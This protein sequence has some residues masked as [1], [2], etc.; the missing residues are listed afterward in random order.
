MAGR[1]LVSGDRLR[2]VSFDLRWGEILGVAGLQEHG[3]R[4]F[5]MTLFG[6]KRLDAGQIV[7]GGRPIRLRSPRDAIRAGLGISLVPEERA[8]E[9]AFL[10]LTG[11]ANMTMP[12]LRRFSTLGWISARKERRAVLEA[13]ERLGISER[14]LVEP[15]EAFS[16]GN[17]QKIV[18][19]KWLVADSRILLM[20]DPTR[21]VDV[22]TKSEIFHLMRDFAEG[23]G[24]VLYYSTDLD[25]I[26]N[27]CD[28]AIVFYRGRIAAELSR[29]AL[30]SENLLTA[31]LGGTL[32]SAAAT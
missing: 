30:S 10:R 23:G 1:A 15:V 5:F 22:R 20:Y 17:Q 8:T 12:S 21:G 25:E 4:D 14:A 24:A 18:I 6:A 3:Q 32:Q 26:V 31:V 29:E 2:G 9:G 16:G 13:L 28:R 11:R 19:A 27:L 7:L